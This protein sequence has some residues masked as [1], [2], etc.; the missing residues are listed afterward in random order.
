MREKTAFLSVVVLTAKRIA[1]RD[2]GFLPREGQ[3]NVA[4]GV[5]LRYPVHNSP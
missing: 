5:S 2:P 3:R 4:W 1:N